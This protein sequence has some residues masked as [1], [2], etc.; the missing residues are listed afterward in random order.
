M[1][2]IRTT[3]PAVSRTINAGPKRSKFSTGT[4]LTPRPPLFEDGEP[5]LFPPSLALRALRAGALPPLPPAGKGESSFS[6]GC[7]YLLGPYG[8]K[9]SS[10]SEAFDDWADARCD[11]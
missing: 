9:P 1:M 11:D 3:T 8:T 4:Y 6:V 2:S 7:Q 10:L 5:V